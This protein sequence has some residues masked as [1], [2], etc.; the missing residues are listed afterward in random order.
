[1]TLVVVAAVFLLTSAGVYLLLAR[2][3]FPT[4]V[5]LALLGHAINLTVLSAGRV[6]DAAPLLGPGG[7]VPLGIADPV[8]QALVLTA[9]VISM[10]VT[11]YLVAIMAVTARRDGIAD[12]EPLPDRDDG[13][14]GDDELPPP[15]RGSDKEA[16]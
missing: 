1:M 4:I 5:G 14:M 6:H 3:V 7:E 9:I 2:R 16:S 15:A 11:L 13:P 8:P 10:A 12:V